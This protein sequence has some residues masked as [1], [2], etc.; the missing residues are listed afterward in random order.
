MA[1]HEVKIR[2]EKV[3]SCA[4]IC[5]SCCHCCYY[6]NT[7]VADA[8]RYK[9]STR[10]RQL[11]PAPVVSARSLQYP[12]QC[13]DKT[14]VVVAA[15]SQPS[16]ASPSEHSAPPRKSRKYV[17]PAVWWAEQETRPVAGKPRNAAVNFDLQCLG[18]IDRSTASV[19]SCL[20]ESR[21]SRFKH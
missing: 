20:L 5:S 10:K 21:V 14:D 15:S 19:A 8:V 4:V 7:N 1:C 2:R 6:N 18:T 11:T 9:I 3:T 16:A 12:R 17:Q 13:R